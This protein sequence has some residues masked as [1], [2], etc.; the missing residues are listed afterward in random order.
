MSVPASRPARRHVVVGGAAALC[1]ALGLSGCTG[2]DAAGAPTA[3]V[4]IEFWHEPDGPHPGVALARE[5]A[6]FEQAHPG[7]RVH[8]EQLPWEEALTRMTTAAA[9]RQGPDV[10]Q[11]GSTWVSSLA[12]QGAFSPL[13]DADLAA[14]GGRDAFVDRAWAAAVPLGATRPVVVPWLL[15]T[16]VVYYRTDVLRAAGV[17]PATAFSTTAAF[18][19]TLGRLQEF[20]GQRPFGFP[21]VSDWNVVHNAMPWIAGAGGRFLDERG[22]VV[23]EEGTVEGLHELQRLVGTH[24]R[25]DVLEGT[26]DDAK[27]GFARGDYPVVVSGPYFA[28]VLADAG[29]DPVVAANWST[30]ELPAGSAGRVGFLG[31]S[32]LAISAHTRH[33]AEALQWVRWL[34]SADSQRR[35][36]SAG[37]MLPSSRAVAVETTAPTAAFTAAAAHGRAYPAVPHWMDVEAQLQNDLSDLWRAVL[38]TGAPLQRQDVAERVAASLQ[39]VGALTLP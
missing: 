27:R 16:R 19:A 32:D 15:D 21:G 8:L 14:V 35:T 9:S 29:T 4:D 6:L 12:A 34:T 18:G 7:V 22:R 13:T 39:R 36:A 20:T 23:H 26:D 38:E 5:V 25:P 31:G 33:R 28:P 10:M 30:A 37:G 1:A 3:P 17:E 24:G 2:G 11:V